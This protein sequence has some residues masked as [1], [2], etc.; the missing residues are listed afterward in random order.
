L[1]QTSYEALVALGHS[2]PEARDLVERVAATKKKFKEV[3]DV[4][5]AIYDLRK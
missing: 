4:L 2:A 3:D 1:F 5:M